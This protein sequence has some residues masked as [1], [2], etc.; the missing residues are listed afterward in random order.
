MS[1]HEHD[2]KVEDVLPA[3]GGIVEIEVIRDG[4]HGP[5]VTQRVT[6]RNLV[7]TSGKK[8]IFRLASDQTTKAVDQFRIGTSAVAAT[9]ADTNVKT[10]VASTIRTA[11]Q[12]T[13]DAG[14]TYRWIVSYGSGAT[15]ISSTNI[16]E[17]VLLTSHTSAGGTCFMRAT[18]TAVNKTKSDKLKIT[19]KCR[20][21]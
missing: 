8:Q 13:I 5:V 16:K 9:A 10:P 17:V 3:M 1:Q 7:V 4:P 6:S 21:T 12:M 19:Y 11:S 2:T 14:R 15:S 20:I 18:F